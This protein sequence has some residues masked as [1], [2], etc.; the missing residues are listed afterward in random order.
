L[1]ALV[2]TAESATL[3]PLGDQR[4]AGE[5]MLRL[6]AGLDAQAGRLMTGRLAQSVIA[7]T[8]HDAASVAAVVLDPLRPL[9]GNPEPVFV[10]TGL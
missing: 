7:A 8:R 3:V 10:P 9:I 2:V 6:R 4:M 1:W 5:A